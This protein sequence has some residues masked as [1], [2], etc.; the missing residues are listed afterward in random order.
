MST[1]PNSKNNDSLEEGCPEYDTRCA[2]CDHYPWTDVFINTDH[3]AR[4][5][6]P[7]WRKNENRDSSTGQFSEAHNQYK[8]DCKCHDVPTNKKLMRFSFKRKVGVKSRHV[9]HVEKLAVC[10][11]CKRS[12][13]EDTVYAHMPRDELLAE[14]LKVTGAPKRGYDFDYNKTYLI[15]GRNTSSRYRTT[16]LTPCTGN[17]K[18]EWYKCKC[19][20]KICKISFRNY[21][22]YEFDDDLF[23]DNSDKWHYGKYSVPVYVTME[24]IEKVWGKMPMYRDNPGSWGWGPSSYF[25]YKYQD[26]TTRPKPLRVFDISGTPEHLNSLFLIEKKEDE[27]KLDREFVYEV[28]GIG[29]TTADKLLEKFGSAD[30]VFS[31]TAEK[32]EKICG[33]PD[34]RAREIRKKLDR[35]AKTSGQKYRDKK[36]EDALLELKK[37]SFNYFYEENSS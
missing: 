33:F 18:H 24:T 7:S 23:G 26:E 5:D 13:F 19:G 16:E 32:I 31:A 17:H 15:H 29:N 30:K 14:D 9:M 10:P 20:R 3:T 4:D 21:F 1:D 28:Y 27:E 37:Y 12:E 35:H 25:L 6:P 22:G 11:F 34:Y 2:N 8:C 36:R